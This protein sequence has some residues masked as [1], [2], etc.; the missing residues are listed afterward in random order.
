MTK[1]HK[2]HTLQRCQLLSQLKE[3][4]AFMMENKTETCPPGVFFPVELG[5]GRVTYPL[6]RDVTLISGEGTALSGGF[7]V[8]VRCPQDAHW[9][10]HD[11]WTSDCSL[12]RLPW[13]PP[14]T[15]SCRWPKGQAITRPRIC[16]H[17]HLGLCSVQNPKSISIVY[18]PFVFTQPR[19]LRKIDAW[20]LIS[21]FSLFLWS[22]C[23][24]FSL[25]RFGSQP[26]RAFKSSVGN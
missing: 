6:L 24:T 9:W 18:K 25:L 16:R 10:V 8:G 26:K 23:P 11:A 22:L 20:N 17:L 3:F 14:C 7:V 12:A 1:K 21:A 4:C 5:G 13:G 19:F 2:D 15:D